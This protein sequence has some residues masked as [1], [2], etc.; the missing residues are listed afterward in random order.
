M[1]PSIK[2]AY[3]LKLVH[4]KKEAKELYQLSFMVPKKLQQSFQKP[5]QYL[6]LKVE[7]IHSFYAM[8]H[9][10]LALLRTSLGAQSEASLA[11]QKKNQQHWEFLI[12][13]DK[14][15]KNDNSITLCNLKEGDTIKASAVMGE[16]F[17]LE[18]VLKIFEQNTELHLFGMGSGI[19][20]LRSLLLNI[21]N[22][23]RDSEIQKTQKIFW[24]KITLWQA[25]FS[26][27]HAAYRREYTDWCQR[28][29]KLKLCL[30][31]T[32]QNGIDAVSGIGTSHFAIEDMEVHSKNPIEVLSKE[33]PDLSRSIVCWAGSEEFGKSLQE[34]CFKLAL[35]K[36]AFLDNLK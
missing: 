14:K 21:L 15:A 7:E 26:R 8:A 16:G 33:K 11:S 22:C 17:T 2:H 35:P 6:S 23:K 32:R 19:A 29:V 31:K 30:D 12:K 9:S 3:L 28:G 10:P 1:S 18:Q 5:G 4:K 24:P 13:N 27:E 36:E 34:L 25:A 20:P